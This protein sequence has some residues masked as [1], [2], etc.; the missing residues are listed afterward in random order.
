[1]AHDHSHSHGSFEHLRKEA[2]RRLGWVL[3]FN[4][5]FL[6]VEVIGGLLSGSLALLADAGHM[7]TDVAALSIAMIATRIA[8]RPPSPRQTFGL[9][10]AEVIGAFI[11]G[12][13]LVIIVGFIF[14]ES[15]RRFGEPAEIDEPLMLGVALAGLIVNVGSA[16][17]LF[18][19]R[20]EN[21]NLKAAFL[22]MAADALGSVS[23]V[24]A[25]VVIWTTGWMPIDLIASLGIGLVIFVSGAGL[26]RE[27]L[28]ILMNA[29][30]R[31]ID[32]DEVKRAL[33]QNPHVAEVHDLHIWSIASG[34]PSLSAHIRLKKSCSD[35]AH[36][37]EC[38]RES[39]DL[40][41]EK[42]GI[43][44]STLQVEPEEYKKDQR[45]I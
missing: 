39:Q 31:E 35:S 24:V 38:L 18:T 10:R 21:V 27:T 26:M 9:L 16:A 12:S 3:L 20:E 19:R 34:V 8:M 6:I 15:W 44:H 41:R 1:M 33:E 36:W 17:V 37:Q 40:L 22:H 13:A 42:F 32:Y 23:A 30:P 7:F 29:T 25:A 2:G 43:L 11:N 4:L 5:F 14:W 28:D 45:P